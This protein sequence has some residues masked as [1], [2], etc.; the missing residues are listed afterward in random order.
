MPAAR[1]NNSRSYELKL[2]AK[3]FFEKNY[4]QFIDNLK[5]NQEKGGTFEHDGKLFEYGKIKRLVPYIEESEVSHVSRIRCRK[6]SS[7]VYSGRKM[8][9][10]PLRLKPPIYSLK[11]MYSW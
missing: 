3:S 1:K 9:M 5:K 7:R 6:P 10:T 2:I 4:E 8:L 11:R